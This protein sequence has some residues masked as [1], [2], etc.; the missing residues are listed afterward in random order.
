[1]ARPQ[2]STQRRYEEA[3]RN[4]RNKKKRIEKEGEKE[5]DENVVLFRWSYASPCSELNK[6]GDDER[7]LLFNSLKLYA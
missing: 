6:S 2:A 1:M 7:E 3:K 5:K 4:E